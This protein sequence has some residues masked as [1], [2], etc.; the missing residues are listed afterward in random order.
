M[1][2]GHMPGLAQFIKSHKKKSH[3][4]KSM[5]DKSVGQPMAQ[6]LRLT[7]VLFCMMQSVN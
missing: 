6:Q 7:P 1:S 3:I 4:L 2:T 5:L